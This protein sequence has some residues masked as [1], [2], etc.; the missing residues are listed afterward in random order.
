MSSWKMLSWTLASAVAGSVT[1][2]EPPPI[3][4]MSRADSAGELFKTHEPVVENQG[5]QT[6]WDVEAWIS[7]ERD[8]DMGIWRTTAMHQEFTDPWPYNEYIQL[9]EGSLTIT[10]SD[11]T[12]TELAAGDSAMIPK[13]WTGTWDTPGLTKIYVIHAAGGGL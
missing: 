6:T 10:T 7:P 13:G 12:V 5:E 4:K 1:A 8:F 3:V 11:G 2:A 9:T